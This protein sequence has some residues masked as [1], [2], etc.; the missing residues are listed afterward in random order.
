VRI[1][2][3]IDGVRVRFYSRISTG[4][5]LHICIGVAGDQRGRKPLSTTADP[6]TNA[7]RL[8]TAASE[9]RSLR[10]AANGGS[11]RYQVE[12]DCHSAEAAEPCNRKCVGATLA[13]G[14]ERKSPADI[15]SPFPMRSAPAAS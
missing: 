14:P 13:R 7:I 9:I 1:R 2:T 5:W 15:A 12:K 3:S 11:R 6:I 8:M 10:R 4:F